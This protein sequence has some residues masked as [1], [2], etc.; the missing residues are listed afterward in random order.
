MK[1]LL[2]LCLIVIIML[3]ICSCSKNSETAETDTTDNSTV[4]TDSSTEKEK[5]VTG[6]EQVDSWVIETTENGLRYSMS[7]GDSKAIIDVTIA[8]DH[9]AQWYYEQDIATYT[10][11]DQLFLEGETEYGNYTYKTIRCDSANPK[12]YTTTDDGTTII[13]ELNEYVDTSRD[14]VK[15]ILGSLNTK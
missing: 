6:I 1:K 3:C 12:L 15:N 4:T 2:S 11:N 13:V 8:T 10:A 9:D 5:T 14:D 7:V